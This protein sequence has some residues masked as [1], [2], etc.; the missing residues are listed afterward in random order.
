MKKGQVLRFVVKPLVFAAALIPAALLVRGAA[1]AS[2]GPNPL[3]TITHGTGD[4]ALRFLLLSLAIT[5]LR[6]V[7]GWNGLI[8]FRR[9]LGLFAFFYASLH[10]LTYLWFDQFF[11][12]RSILADI[13]KR[14]FI[15]AGFLAFVALVPLAVTSTAGMIRRLGGRRWRALHRLVYLAA[16]VAVTHY[17]WLMKA[18]TSKPR[19]DASVLVVLLAARGLVAWRRRMSTGRRFAPQSA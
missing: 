3:E 7:T 6:T 19:L 18:D 9:M 2:L 14:P 12:W 8:R 13:P 10:L 5:P 11:S 15:T 17:W 16:G 1:S 4:W